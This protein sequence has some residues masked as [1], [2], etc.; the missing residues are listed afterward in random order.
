MRNLQSKK[1]KMRY[2]ILIEG[3]QAPV[4][5]KF[6]IEKMASANHLEG[7]C[8]IHLPSG[9]GKKTE[10]PSLTF[11]ADATKEFSSS[12]LETLKK[13]NVDFVFCFTDQLPSD[14]W[15]ASAKHGFWRF[16]FGDVLR[17]QNMG[18]RERI[19]KEFVQCVQLERVIS[20]VAEIQILKEGHF[21]L[22]Q[23]SVRYHMNASLDK[24]SRW[25]ADIAKQIMTLGGVEVVSRHRQDQTEP[26][27]IEWFAGRALGHFAAL[28]FQFARISRQ[29][30]YQQWNV[31]LL[32][33]SVSDLVANRE[34]TEVKWWKK[35]GEFMCLADPFPVV[36]DD[37]L[38]VLAEEFSYVDHKGSIVALTTNEAGQP[39]A[40]HDALRLDHHLSYPCSVK[41][42]GDLFMVNEAVSRKELAIYKCNKFPNIWQ[43]QVVIAAGEGYSDPTLFRFENRWWVFATLFSHY[44]EGHST[45][46]AWYSESGL[47][48]PWQPHLLNPIKCDI[49][50][51][52]GAGLPFWVGNECYRPA[53]NCSKFYGSSVVINRI[54]K[55]TPWSFAEVP[56]REIFPD[57]Q[58]PNGLHHLAGAGSVTVIDGR[59]DQFSFRVGIKKMLY[60][61][62]QRQVRAEIAAENEEL[63]RA[64]SWERR[65]K[66][67]S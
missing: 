60:H 49:R 28:R 48:G 1:N 4:W 53:Q 17:P 31:G 62:R 51:S 24:C 57:S 5:A 20:R 16:R 47:E 18:V 13:L 14:D 10:E 61:W 8:W 25:P 27:F 21:R 33:Q 3:S 56:V 30:V 44:T 2:A 26:K 9:K 67:L 40:T 22:H 54:L 35:T 59:R 39:V 45:L 34:M 42:D 41:I 38:F 64:K 29:F 55:L 11:M 65:E 46:C 37:Q 36:M 12:S 15:L 19:K 50:S 32:S 23:K 7:I 63:S 66:C 52:R 6:A 58:F 43:K